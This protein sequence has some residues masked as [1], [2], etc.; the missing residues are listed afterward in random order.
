MDP[1]ALVR[2]SQNRFK[3]WTW[4]ELCLLT[5]LGIEEIKQKIDN[6]DDPPD[7]F[8]W[9]TQNHK[10]Y[11]PKA[12]R[13]ILKYYPDPEMFQV[14]YTA[15]GVATRFVMVSKTPLWASYVFDDDWYWK[16]KWLAKHK[17]ILLKIPFVTKVY[18]ACSV[19]SEISNQNSDIDLLIQ[20]QPNTVWLV[21]IYFA[22]ISKILKYYN[23]PWLQGFWLWLKNDK[24]QLEDL[25]HKVLES[26]FKIDFGLVFEDW[27]DVER[28]YANKERHFSIWNNID[29]KEDLSYYEPAFTKI[30]STILL[31]FYWLLIPLFLIIG[32]LHFWYEYR[33]YSKN[34]NMVVRWKIYSQYNVIF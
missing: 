22:V 9:Y 6:Q 4:P 15:E 29:V 16:Q 10:N 14:I 23:F 12:D 18:L 7:P 17:S 30:L 21:K 26:K 2:H 34:I 5:G 33:F 27:K 28:I 24:T 32:L 13:A 3:V 8:Y 1:I 11:N 20:V 25:K 19:A 31:P